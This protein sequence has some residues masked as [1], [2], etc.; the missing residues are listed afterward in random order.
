MCVCVCVSAEFP[1]LLFH[2]LCVPSTFRGD[3][4]RAIRWV[5]LRGAGRPLISRAKEKVAAYHLDGLAQMR[6]SVMRDCAGDCVQ[7]CYR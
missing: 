5:L 1:S 7:R 4:T 6:R 2:D 3:L